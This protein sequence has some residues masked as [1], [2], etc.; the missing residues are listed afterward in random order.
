MCTDEIFG[1]YPWYRDKNIR[2]SHGFPWAQNT[3]Y[4]FGFLSASMK[5]RISPEY[6]KDRYNS[7]IHDVSLS[8]NISPLEKR[9]REMFVLN[10]DHFMQTLLFRKDSC[11]M[12]ASLEVRVP[13]CDR[14]ITEYLYCVP[15]EYKDYEGRE[16]GLLRHAFSDI[17]PHDIVWRKKSPYP[18]THNPGYLTALRE[19]FSSLLKDKDNP[20]WSILDI[21]KAATLMSGETSLPWYGQLMT[22]P[23]TI[24]YFIQLEYWL[25]KFSV[26][27]SEEA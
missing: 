8:D 25:R 20:L 2:D 17:L 7:A 21:G 13:F 10:L 27:F 1:G 4:R 18:K 11:S 19:I 12:H 6:V 22:T 14:R 26:T 15:W 24:A 23:Q 3:L 9:M 5:N 16:K